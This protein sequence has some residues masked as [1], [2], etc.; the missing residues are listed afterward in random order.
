MILQA[1]RYTQ[2]SMVDPA[3]PKSAMVD[4]FWH[5]LIITASVVT[6]IVFV[7]LII[8]LFKRRRPVEPHRRG[9][10]HDRVRDRL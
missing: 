3:G 2:Q 10:V 7:A 1:P 6:A 8:A 9:G 4:H 5:F